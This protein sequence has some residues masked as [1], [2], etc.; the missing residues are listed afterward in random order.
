MR[1]VAPEL[2]RV[3][4]IFPWKN[5][6]WKFQ[7]SL[8]LEFS[9]RPCR[10]APYYKQATPGWP[11]D[12]RAF[13]LWWRQS[14]KCRW[15]WGCPLGGEPDLRSFSCCSLTLVLLS[16]QAPLSWMPVSQTSQPS[17]YLT[18]TFMGFSNTSCSNVWYNAHFF[19][20]AMCWLTLLGNMTIIGQYIQVL[21]GVY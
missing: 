1:S 13:K 10:W 5:P 19:E 11:L 18:L 14:S 9:S 17:C 7:P 15:L 21:Q 16:L 4:R 3:F 6:S 2:T 20:E 12:V 8:Q